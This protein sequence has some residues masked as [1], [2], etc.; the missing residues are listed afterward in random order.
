MRI[1]RVGQVGRHRHVGRYRRSG[2][3]HPADRA[4]PGLGAIVTD[5]AGFTLYRF[6]QD[7]TSPPESYCNGNRATLRPPEQAHG[8]VTAKGTDSKPLGT[9]TRSGGVERGTL[10]GSP[11]PADPTPTSSTP[12]YRPAGCPMAADRARARPPP[13]TDGR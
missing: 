13:T 12:G 8:N 11:G 1:I 4:R 7:G 9:G 3:C 5:S 2:R 10:N 6:D